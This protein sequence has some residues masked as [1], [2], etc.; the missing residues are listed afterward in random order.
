[1]IRIKHY[2]KEVIWNIDCQKLPKAKRI[3]LNILKGF[4]ITIKKFIENKISIHV[5]SLTFFT[6]ISVVPMIALA[7]GV[8]K[9]FGLE[10][11]LENILRKNFTGQEEI[12]DYLL[13]FSNS[14]LES[15]KGGLV[16]LVSVF[17]LLF[18]VLR[19][20]KKIE[21]VFNII[22]NV[23]TNKK[24]QKKIF[25]H[26]VIVIVS[27][28]VVILATG[29]TLF[30]KTI[31]NALADNLDFIVYISSALILILKILPYLL[32]WI[33]FVLMF[34]YLPNTKVKITSAIIAG[35]IAGVMYQ[36]TQWGYIS[37]Q[38]G[39]GRFNAIYGSFAALPLFLI[40]IQISWYIILF[41]AQVA[42]VVQK[43]DEI[44]NEIK[45]GKI[46]INQ[47]RWMA[48]LILNKILINFKNGDEI[49]SI[50]KISEK[51]NIHSK[52]IEIIVKELQKAN[53][54][55]KVETENKDKREFLPTIDIKNYNIKF[56][57]DKLNNL[58]YG[59]ALFDKEL[60]G[61][62][63][64]FLKNNSKQEFFNSNVVDIKI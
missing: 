40:W 8:T 9:G 13:N 55:V 44:T 28:I 47:K 57:L 32:L 4:L 34:V 64:D 59:T 53:L 46:S 25:D 31:N 41:S 2:F 61:K 6:I 24:L 39:V 21:V 22:W 52:Q 50:N 7:F 56:I 38:I 58:N 17:F 36:L 60:T 15:T 43:F 12:L 45:I 16:A 51:I 11:V 63:S 54:I 42:F 27:A 35:L 30:I 48:L 49:L 14:L 20:I 26:L 23:K 3:L 37:L 19:M 29:L 33:I 10:T 5:A 62:Y 1:M 18:F